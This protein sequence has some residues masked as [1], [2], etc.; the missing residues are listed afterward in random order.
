MSILKV[1]QNIEKYPYIKQYYHCYLN[2]FF[3]NKHPLADLLSK[4]DIELE[5][6]EKC[7]Q[8]LQTINKLSH[9]IKK[10]RNKE[11]FYSI[12]SEMKAVI[13]FIQMEIPVDIIT[14]KKSSP[15]LII[16]IDNCKISCEIKYLKDK[17]SEKNPYVL[18]RIDDEVTIKNSIVKSVKKGQYYN[19]FPHIF[20]FYLNWSADDLD[21]EDTLCSSRDGFFF[22][23]NKNNELVYG[24]IS[25]IAVV[26]EKGSRYHE[27]EQLIIKRPRI[28][29]FPNPNA[30]YV[31]ENVN[32]LGFEAHA[33]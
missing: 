2:Q 32:R 27:Q 31:I 20:M 22:E 16:E 18:S 6:L 29:Y 3:K 24:M 5:G 23:K 15:D 4:N 11:D 9:L 25:G 28:M 10:S 30:K 17:L 19:T 12:Y 21:F 13:S 7:L 26:F 14:D 33:V 8:K 1:N